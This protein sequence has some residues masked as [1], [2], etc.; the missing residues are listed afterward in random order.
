[1]QTSLKQLQ[2]EEKLI[3]SKTYF[4][5]CFCIR[6]LLDFLLCS[7]FCSNSCAH[8]RSRPHPSTPLQTIFDSSETFSNDKNKTLHFLTTLIKI[9][10]KILLKWTAKL[11]WYKSSGI[12]S[13]LKPVFVNWGTSLGCLKLLRCSLISSTRF[14]RSQ[15]IRNPHKSVKNGKTSF[16]Q[17]VYH[18]SFSYFGLCQFINSGIC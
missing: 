9:G 4:W 10:I 6:W 13:F 18:Q 12:L 16:L 15:L 2:T 8:F 17:N 7:W 1:M 3:I 11:T 5:Y 14:N